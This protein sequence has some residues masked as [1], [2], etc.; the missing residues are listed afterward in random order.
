MRCTAFKAKET[1]D[2]GIPLQYDL[3]IQTVLMLPSRSAHSSKPV[4]EVPRIKFNMVFTF[5]KS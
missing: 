4:N 3:L 2:I 5:Y 1:I